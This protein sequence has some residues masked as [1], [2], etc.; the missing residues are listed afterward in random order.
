MGF[1]LTHRHRGRRNLPSTSQ[2]SVGA[3]EQREAAIAF[4][5]THRHRGLAVLVRSYKIHAG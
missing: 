3:H 1:C 5:L 4:C 2:D